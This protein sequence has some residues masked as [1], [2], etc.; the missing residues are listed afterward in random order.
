MSAPADQTPSSLDARTHTSTSSSKRTSSIVVFR[1]RIK[2]A[3]YVFALGLFSQATATRSFFSR[4]M[5]VRSIGPPLDDLSRNLLI[6]A[7]PCETSVAN[8]LAIALGRSAVRVGN[9]LWYS[10]FRDRLGLLGGVNH[11]RVD[12]A[13]NGSFRGPQGNW[14]RVNAERSV[15]EHVTPPEVTRLGPYPLKSL[16]SQAIGVGCGE[17]GTHRRKFRPKPV[18]ALLHTV[19]DL[20]KSE[21]SETF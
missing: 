6:N 4:E 3:S 8:S 10:K 14:S 20:L 21:H 7:S 5:Y 18:H 2:S 15:G 17:L 9:Q 16:S 11:R 19:D 12:L 13:P 1:S